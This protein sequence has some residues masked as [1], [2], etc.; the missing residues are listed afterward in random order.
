MEEKR[1]NT[2]KPSQRFSE[3]LTLGSGSTASRAL[4][5]HSFALP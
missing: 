2:L 5:S 3:R 1:N 4:G